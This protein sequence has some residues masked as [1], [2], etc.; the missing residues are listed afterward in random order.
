MS[1][2]MMMMSMM[3]LLLRHPWQ[4]EEGEH[5]AYLAWVVKEG[6]LGEGPN[7]KK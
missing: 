6:N 5:S 4:Q 7:E 3:T 1:V 2:M